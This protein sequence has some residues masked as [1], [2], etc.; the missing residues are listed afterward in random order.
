[1]MG[2]GRVQSVARFKWKL[3]ELVAEDFHK[4]NICEKDA[5]VDFDQ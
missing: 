2:V 1:M 3:K 5:G 4:V